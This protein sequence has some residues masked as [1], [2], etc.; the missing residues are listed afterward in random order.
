MNAGAVVVAA[1]E[2]RRF[3]GIVP[4]QFSNLC[5]RPLLRWTLDP[6][7]SLP[8]IR[9]LVLVLPSSYIPEVQSHWRLPERVR[10]VKGG[11]TRLES[12]RRGL[13]ALSPRCQVV[14]IHDGARP[15]VS[16]QLV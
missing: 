5:G 4:K 11:A 10:C 1:G 8:L 7:L 12:V 6:F 2:G 3:G 16:P 9:E 14:G 13:K 15:L